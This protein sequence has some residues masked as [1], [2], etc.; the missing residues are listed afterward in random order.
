[1]RTMKIL[2]VSFFFPPV[3]AVATVR[4][5]NLC[6]GLLAAGHSVQVVTVDWRE[7]TEDRIE[8]TPD[9]DEVRSSSAYSEIRVASPW[10][11]LYGGHT[12]KFNIDLT[13]R[14]K[15]VFTRIVR[16][17]LIWSGFDPMLLW[18]LSAWKQIRVAT[19]VD[20]VLVSGGPFSSFLPSY[21]LAKLLKLPLA[22]DYRD[23]WNNSPHIKHRLSMRFLERTILRR[24]TLV[25]SVSPSCLES[26]LEKEQCFS[27][28]ITNG[29]AEDVYNY[30]ITQQKEYKPFV[31]YAGA[32]YPPKRSIKPFFS[33]LAKL[34]ELRNGQ[35]DLRFIYLGPS[36]EYV[37]KAAEAYD[38]CNVVDC[39]GMVSHDVALRLQAQSLCTLVVTTVDER[40][41]GA[42]RGILTGKLFEA[43]EL[44]CQVLVISPINSDA[45]ELTAHIPH[46]HHFTGM[47]SHSMAEWLEGLTSVSRVPQPP[48]PEYFSWTK[49]GSKFAQ[50]LSYSEFDL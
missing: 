36:V 40:A 15:I 2:F 45:R 32:F 6:K 39:R 23:V 25:T 9:F 34:R 33:A 47:E 1:M 17:I 31:I 35:D 49:L 46:V 19:D 48:R 12:K 16:K 8:L 22:L 11:E 38:L 37:K 28:V 29:V 41:E 10:P 4:T 21:F 5:W 14:V 27:S 44:A 18:S 42:D 50:L 24:A 26:I 43:I 13:W 3:K 7:F 30:R 20:L